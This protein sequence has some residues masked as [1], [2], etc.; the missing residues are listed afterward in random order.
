MAV[1]SRGLDDE[2][3]DTR[4]GEATLGRAASAV[5]LAAAAVLPYPRSTFVLGLLVF[6]LLCQPRRV[7]AAMRQVLPASLLLFL[8][9]CACSAYWSISPEGTSIVTFQVFAST[10]LV[11]AALA[12]RSREQ[13]LALVGDTL[14]ALLL[15]SWLVALLA[16]SIGLTQDPYEGGSLEGLFV[17]RNLLGYVAATSVLTALSRC[18]LPASGVGGRAWPVI[19]VVVSV[20]TLAASQSRTAWL[21]TVAAVLVV[22]LA[23]RAVGLAG[24]RAV[25]AAL[26][27]LVCGAASW[28]VISRYT[29]VAAAVGRDATLTGRTDIWAAVLERVAARPVLGYGWGGVWQDSWLADELAR[30]VGFRFYHAHSGF[31]DLLLQVGVVGTVLLVLALAQAVALLMPEVGRD[32]VASWG[33]GLAVVLALTSLTETVV[34]GGAGFVVI[35]T[36]CWIALNRA[37][38]PV[39]GQETFIRSRTKG[40]QR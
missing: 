37:R 10:L 12:G 27:M 33:L 19:G 38:A 39:A 16:P 21:V 28:W 22:A 18:A 35:V 1:R 32:P 7:H 23:R 15:V 14:I 25:T 11:L 17:H 36:V 24:P 26:S 2:D 6:V 31:L 30:T 29:E 9:W 13:V 3:R 20:L 4:A 40:E 8:V 34:V 5:V